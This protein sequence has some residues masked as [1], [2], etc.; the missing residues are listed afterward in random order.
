M[1]D[2]STLSLVVPVFNEADSI[3][4]FINKINGVFSGRSDIHLEIVFI[5]DG[6]SDST[7]EN[8]I[9][10]QSDYP[11]IKIIDL[12][13][14]FGKEAAITAGLEQSRGDAVVVIDVDLQDPPELI[15]SMIE[16]WQEGY[17]VVLACRTNR[18]SDSWL[19]RASANSFYWIHN[20]LSNPKIPANVGDFRLMDRVVVE[21]LKQLPETH[22]FMKG[23]FSWVGFKST[24]IN[25][26]RPKRETGVSK[27]NGWK[28]WNFALEGLTSFSTEPLRIW[29]YIGLAVSI[30]SFLF[31]VF[32]AIRVLISG[33]DVPG[34]ASIMVAVTFLG[35]LQLIGIGVLGEYMGRTYMESKR[36]PN[37][38]IRKIF[39]VEN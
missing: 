18:D 22:R 21:A 11:N 7:L 26:S 14:N 31:A 17:E 32:I 13:R 27:F 34:Y 4:P 3:S 16:K 36:R 19:K 10:T 33:V 38:I 30:P 23:L 2:K 25:Y 15:P 35:G 20:Q 9:Q 1:T 29:T 8:L 28:L 24:V 6:S 12:S 37:Y 39:E 5:N